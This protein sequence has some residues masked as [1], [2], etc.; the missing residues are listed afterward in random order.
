LEERAEV[1]S[2]HEDIHSAKKMY[3]NV[4]VGRLELE[5]KKSILES[6]LN[7]HLMRKKRDLEQAIHERSVCGLDRTE[8]NQQAIRDIEAHLKK[9]DSSFKRNKDE[10]SAIENKITELTNSIVA[11]RN[12]LDK[13]SIDLQK[14]EILLEKSQA[15]VSN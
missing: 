2:L 8:A 15:V 5:G 14:Q 6:R 9:L 11:E 7:D 3:Q 13:F 10:I 12:K 4:N 1:E